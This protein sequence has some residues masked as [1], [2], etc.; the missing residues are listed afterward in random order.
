MGHDL[1]DRGEAHTLCM[2]VHVHYNL[3]TG[4]MYMLHNLHTGRLSSSSLKSITEQCSNTHHKVGTKSKN[5]FP[6]RM[7]AGNIRKNTYT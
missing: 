3:H 1:V 5:T 7:H 6:S 2:H 4:C